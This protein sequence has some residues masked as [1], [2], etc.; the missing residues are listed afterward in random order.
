MPI[1]VTITDTSTGI[2]EYVGT[3]DDAEQCAYLGKLLD[4]LN[5]A[6]RAAGSNVSYCMDS[7]KHLGHDT[8]EEWLSNHTYQHNRG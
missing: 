5:L 4:E 7:W 8:R 6:R 1:Q 3:A 2:I